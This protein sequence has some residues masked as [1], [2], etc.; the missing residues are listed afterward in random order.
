MSAGVLVHEWLAPRGGSENVFEAMAQTFPD[1]DLLCLW[2]DAPGRFPGR[3]VA[4]TRLARTS[5]R[6]SKAAALP[7]MPVAWRRQP[8]RYDW[9]LVSSHAFAHHVSFVDQPP[10]FRK[11]LYVHTPAR[12]L[13]EP[14]LDGRAAGRAG[15]LAAA[16]LRV[17]DRRRAQEATAVAVNSATVRDRVRRVWD[18]DATVIHP[19]VA[20]AELQRGGRWLERLDPAD[21]AVLAAIP[22]PFLLGASRFVA[23]KNLDL[24]IDAGEAVGLPVV[25]AGSGPQAPHLRARAAAAE[26]PVHVVLAPSDTLLRALLQEAAVLVFPAVEDFGIL[27]VEA[28][29]LGTPVLGPSAGGVSETVEHGRTGALL[30]GPPTPS[31][32]REGVAT[33]VACAADACRDSA[34]RFAVERFRDEIRG[35]VQRAV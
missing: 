7:F 28:L 13:W 5:L 22:R 32:W 20:V 3:D 2:D 9:A 15:R 33:A 21:A 18:R 8:G 12:Y 4:E 14:E 19:P 11:L 16:P 10:A 24:V 34:A 1:A 6:T 30:T 26:V 31:A 23:Y 35:W 25:I 29:A 17:L 27:P